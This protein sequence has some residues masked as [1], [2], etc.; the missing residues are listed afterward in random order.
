MRAV[1]PR[2]TA[3][4]PAKALREARIGPRPSKR[5]SN[6]KFSRPTQYG[7]SSVGTNQVSSTADTQS[8]FRPGPSSQHGGYTQHSTH[9][10]QHGNRQTTSTG[11][12]P[13]NNNPF[14]QQSRQ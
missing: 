8:F 4:A 6:E 10:R 5:F 9:S 3:S 2:F 11:A 13:K 14:R 7:N 1:N 12:H